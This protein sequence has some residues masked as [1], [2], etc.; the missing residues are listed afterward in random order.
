MDEFPAPPRDSYFQQCQVENKTAFH[1]Y[2]STDRQIQGSYQ[3]Y[4][5]GHTSHQSQ[6]GSGQ[7][8]RSQRNEVHGYQSYGI[9]QMEPIRSDS[10]RPVNNA[11][12]NYRGEQHQNA[13]DRAL[14]QQ[15]AKNMSFERS[16]P[17]CKQSTL[18][19]PYIVT[20]NIYNREVVFTL[21]YYMKNSIIR[22][23]VIV[24]LHS[25]IITVF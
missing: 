12:N 6:A 18:T 8:T 2:A 15:S 1:P 14:L 16:I 13:I 5:S 4:G 22:N 7:S 10:G 3:S 19:I 9:E 24:A 21:D 23:K 20:M 11:D 25:F 17:E